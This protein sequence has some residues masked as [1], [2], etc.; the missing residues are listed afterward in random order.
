MV[1]TDRS[2]LK[3]ILKDLEDRR[4]IL[5][6]PLDKFKRALDALFGSVYEPFEAVDK[7]VGKKVSDYR[8]RQKAAAAAEQARLQREAEARARKEREEWERKVK[9]Q[10]EA[11]ERERKEREAREA[12]QRALEAKKGKK[13]S[14]APLPPPPPPAPPPP[15]PPPP[16]FTPAPVI[17]AAPSTI[18]PLSFRKIWQCDIEDVMALIQAVA[19]GHVS[20]S[21]LLPNQ[22]ILNE[23]VR[24]QGVREIPGCKIWEKEIDATRT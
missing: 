6:G 14:L 20:V 1:A 4:K 13:E 2:E 12:A 19:A 24:K 8:E 16:V 11:Q 7:L 23:L 15:P 17:P 3:R 5:T 18:G 22:T 9:A 10:Q 21:V